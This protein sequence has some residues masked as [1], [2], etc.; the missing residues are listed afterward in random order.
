MITLPK[1]K[2]IYLEVLL[3]ETCKAKPKL[4]TGMA[5][6]KCSTACV[7]ELS[8]FITQTKEWKLVQALIEHGTVPDVRCIEI[9]MT[10]CSSEDDA[11]YLI[12]QV[13]KAQHSICYNTLLSSAVDKRWNNNFVS[14]CL[15]YGAKLAAKQIWTVLLWKNSPEKD[16]LLKLMVSQ[17]IAMD[18]RNKKGQLPLESLLQEGRSNTAL[19]L[20]EFNLDTSMI[21]IIKTIQTL[22]KYSADKHPI[23][24]LCRIIENKKINPDLLKEELT[25]ALMYAF[26]NSRYEVAA[27]LIDYGADIKSCVDESTTIVHVAT[28]IVLRT[29]GK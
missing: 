13:E 8:K 29:S 21:D 28:D 22:K 19:T 4:K 20:L 7:K 15:Q 6:G 12:K 5:I 1:F 17:D 27:V 2:L 14:H 10:H 24:I 9:A 25:E 16:N 3:L 11:L 23:K 18:V 26:K